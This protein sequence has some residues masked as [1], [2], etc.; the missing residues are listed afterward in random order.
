MCSERKMTAQVRGQESNTCSQSPLFQERAGGTSS[1][2]RS[3]GPGEFITGSSLCMC[4]FQLQGARRCTFARAL[5]GDF[6][7]LQSKHVLLLICQQSTN[8]GEWV[9]SPEELYI[10]E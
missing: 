9:L 3:D 8:I 2:G 6:V 10:F 5:D 4:V 7:C 1:L